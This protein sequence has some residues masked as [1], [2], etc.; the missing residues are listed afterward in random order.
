MPHTISERD[1]EPFWFLQPAI[2]FYRLEFLPSEG[3]F[4][5]RMN[6]VARW[7]MLM[8]GAL[9][10]G[11]VDASRLVAGLLLANVVIYIVGVC[12]EMF[13]ATENK[14]TVEHF[15]GCGVHR[16]PSKAHPFDLP[17]RALDPVVSNPHQF[18]SINKKLAGHGAHPATLIAP[19]VADRMGDDVWGSNGFAVRQQINAA[20]APDL[21][22]SGYLSQP[23]AREGFAP[24][25]YFENNFAERGLPDNLAPDQS[26]LGNQQNYYS[27]IIHPGVTSVSQ[28][29]EPTGTHANIGISSAI[30]MRD[31]LVEQTADGTLITYQQP[32]SRVVAPID[33]SYAEPAVHNVY[34]PRSFGHGD[35][36]RAYVDEMTGRVK[37]SYQDVDAITRPNFVSRNKLDHTSF[38]GRY[39]PQDTVVTGGVRELAQGEFLA[40]SLEHRTDMME[41][42]LRPRKAME[43][44]RKIAPIHTRNT[45]RAGMGGN[46]AAYAGAGGGTVA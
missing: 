6:A 43:W 38:G 18:T 13:Q 26:N 35:A 36:S 12:K 45:A 4:G 5:R 42:L 9:L 24:Q 28:V 37:F 23:E 27:T 19:I 1:R 39:G 3:S 2:L 20:T 8:G 25:G 32:Q 34:D 46:G 7:T 41:K 11:G 14:E 30:Q 44:Q 15:S 21:L 29:I 17:Q 16:A 10:L 31:R 33:P 22:A 40:S